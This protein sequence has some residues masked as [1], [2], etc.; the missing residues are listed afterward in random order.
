MADDTLNTVVA[1]KYG[2][3]KVAKFGQYACIKFG[4]ERRFITKARAL[5]VKVAG[6]GTQNVGMAGIAVGTALGGVAGTANALQGVSVQ[7]LEITWKDGTVSLVRVTKDIAEAITIGMYSDWSPET[8]NR[9]AEGQKKEEARNNGCLWLIVA[10]WA[11][12]L[13]YCSLAY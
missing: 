9:M 6:T 8:E 2:G 13:I 10:A 3:H 4:E 11:V 7:L 5:Q 12:F 1:G